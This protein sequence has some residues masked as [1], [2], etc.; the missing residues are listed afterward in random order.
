MDSSR[1]GLPV[2]SLRL[3]PNELAALEEAQRIMGDATLSA[4]MRRALV[5]ASRAVLDA[6]DRE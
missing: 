3:P 6:T 4:F 5:T 1:P 2:V